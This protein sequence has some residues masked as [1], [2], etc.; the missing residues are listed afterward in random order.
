M[1]YQT[2]SLVNRLIA[3]P[4]T[5]LLSQVSLMESLG[6]KTFECDANKASHSSKKIDITVVRLLWI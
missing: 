1:Y 5:I 4:Y 6:I 3:H 2:F